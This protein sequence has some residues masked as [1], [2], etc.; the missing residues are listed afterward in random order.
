VAPAFQFQ[1]G[2]KTIAITTTGQRRAR[3]R[4]GQATFW[5][6]LPRAQKPAR[7]EAEWGPAR[8]AWRRPHRPTRPKAPPP[9]ASARGFIAGILAGADK[10]ARIA[11]WRGDPVLPARLLDIERHPRPVAAL[12][13]AG[14]ASTARAGTNPDISSSGQKI[15]EVPGVNRYG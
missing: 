5:A 6:F 10:L 14:G 2:R 8:L 11:H 3:P 4:G 15:S 9:A 1:A 12:A 7:G 13:L